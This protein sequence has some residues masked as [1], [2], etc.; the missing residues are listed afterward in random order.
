MLGGFCFFKGDNMTIYEELADI[1]N[2]VSVPFDINKLCEKAKE[3]F[4]TYSFTEKNI[5]NVFSHYDYFAIIDNCASPIEQIFYIA[6]IFYV[7]KFEDIKVDDYSLSFLLLEEI[8]SQYTII[9]EDKKYNVDFVLDFSRKNKNGEYIYPFIKKLKY[10]IELDGFDY[11][12]SK[13][14][15]NYDYERENNLKIQGY[16][17]IRFTGSQLYTNPYKCI[18]NLIKIIINDIK[19]EI[20]KYE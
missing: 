4:I 20:K 18:Y 8:C 7:L 14:Q 16:N 2:D 19:R 12:S 6:Y 11:H 9:W 15:M 13:Q 1:M 5:E 10:A 3:M 17:V